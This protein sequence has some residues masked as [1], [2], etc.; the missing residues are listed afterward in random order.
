MT[1]KDDELDDALTELLAR[2]LPQHPASLTLKRR[3]AAQWPEPVPVTPWWRRQRTWL[4]GAAAAA[5]IAVA[6]PVVYEQVVTGPARATDA[7]LAEAVNDHVRLVQNPAPLGVV[8]SGMHDV[9]P[10]FTGKLD[11][12]PVVRFMGDDEF[13]LRGGALAYFVDRPAA[14]FVYARRKHTVTLLVFQAEKLSVPTQTATRAVRGF[15]VMLWRDG[16]LGY[17]LVSDVD[18]TDLDALRMRL[19]PAER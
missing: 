16:E 9:K 15:N 14:A 12:A 5:V 18:R 19:A 4:A 6:A 2:R 8:S 17:A 11:F 13:P 1:M 3:L 7:L 10:W